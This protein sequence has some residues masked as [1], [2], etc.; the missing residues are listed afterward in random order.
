MTQLTGSPADQDPSSL[1]DSMQGSC[2]C[3][4][5]TVKVTLPGLFD[6]PIGH[7]C[8]CYNCRQSSGASGMNILTVPTPNLT[9]TDSK[10]YLKTYNDTNTGSGNT[11]ARSFC[12]NCGSTIGCLP[13]LSAPQLSMV[14]LGLFPRIPVPEFEVFTKHRQSWLKPAA[15]E[16]DQCDFAEEFPKYVGKYLQ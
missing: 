8:H 14:A 12:S 9:Y 2:L 6:N 1:K 10:N 4:S 7:I 5:I 3:G 16:E 13:V 11:V 15:R